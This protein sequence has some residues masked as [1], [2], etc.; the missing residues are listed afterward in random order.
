MFEITSLLLVYIQ[1]QLAFKNI[2]KFV[3]RF[4]QNIKNKF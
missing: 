2:Y 4:E 3:F 1:L